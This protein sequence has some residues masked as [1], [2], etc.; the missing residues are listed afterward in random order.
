MKFLLKKLWGWILSLIVV[1]SYV[2]LMI[3]YRQQEHSSYYNLIDLELKRILPLVCF[4]AVVIKDNWVK[5]GMILVN[6][7]VMLFICN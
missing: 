3:L 1:G 5:G 7:I 2:G 6:C 4:L